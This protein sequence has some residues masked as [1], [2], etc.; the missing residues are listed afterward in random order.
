MSEFVKR[1]FGNV[2]AALVVG[3]LVSFSIL[4]VQA[5]AIVPADQQFWGSYDNLRFG[6]TAEVPLVGFSA[7]SPPENGDGQGYI[8]DSGEA[9]IAVY[10]GYWT[11]LADSFSDY[12]VLQRQYLEDDGADITYEPSGSDWFVFSGYLGNQ[13]FYIKAMTTPNC[14]AAGH[15]YFLFPTAKRDEMSSIIEYMEDSLSLHAS[16]ACPAG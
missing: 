2:L 12:R 10:G 5:Q 11:V 1:G 3:W 8:S 13:I 14:E 15:I 6:V 16:D 7:M 9:Q 4:Q